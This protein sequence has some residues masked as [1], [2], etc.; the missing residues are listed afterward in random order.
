MGKLMSLLI[1]VK[2]CH[3]DRR[4]GL[5]DALRSTWVRDLPPNVTTRFFM[6]NNPDTREGTNL[7]KDEI[8]LDVG[9]SY[10]DLPFKTREITKWMV[11]RIFDYVFFCDNDTI[12]KSAK[13]LL[14]IPYW[15]ADYTGY[16][17]RN[18]DNLAQQFFYKDHTGDYPECWPWASG[19]Y[20]YFLSREAAGHVADTYPKVWAEDMYVG[21]VIGPLAAQGWLRSQMVNMNAYAWHFRKSGLYPTF[22]PALMHRIYAEGGPTNIYK[23]AV[24]Y[25]ARTK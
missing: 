22:T 18:E 19:G 20:G 25:N 12:V 10:A 5:H 13:E 14:T 21:Q 15:K 9:D 24:D 17:G 4:M 3:R 11:G 1:A 16:F 6:G 7:P 23:E 8:A 2:S